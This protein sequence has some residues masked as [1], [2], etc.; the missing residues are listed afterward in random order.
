MLDEIDLD[1]IPE[2]TNNDLDSLNLDE[3]PEGDLE[4]TQTG[5]P[6]K[7]GRAHV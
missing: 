7:I 1:E 3:I 6:T 2:A 5:F 4:G